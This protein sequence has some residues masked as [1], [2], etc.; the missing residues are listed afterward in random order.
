MH[1]KKMLDR[2][3]DKDNP[4]ADEWDM[5]WGNAFIEAASNIRT[6]PGERCSRHIFDIDD[7]VD[8]VASVCGEADVREWV[9]LVELDDGR[10]AFISAG[11]GG[12]A[13]T[14]G[15]ALVSWDKD[16]LISGMTSEERHLLR[17]GIVGRA[18]LNAR[19]GYQ[20]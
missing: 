15:S 2:W 19:G 12:P 1:A 14:S 4:Y 5:D 8:V 17:S 7:I 18:V 10:F 6:I 20:R 3:Q 11:V 13:G 9:A 16:R